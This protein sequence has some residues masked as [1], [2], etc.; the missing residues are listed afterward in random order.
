MIDI[1]REEKTLRPTIL[2]NAAVPVFSSIRLQL[3]EIE[4]L[5][6]KYLYQGVNGEPREDTVQDAHQWLKAGY[7]VCSMNLERDIMSVSTLPSTV[8]GLLLTPPHSELRCNLYRSPVGAGIDLHFDGT[9][10]II[11]QYSGQKNWWV[12]RQR[13][14]PN[15]H[16]SGNHFPVSD[17][18]ESCYDG[19]RISRPREEELDLFV[20]NPGDILVLPRGYWHKTIATSTSTSLTIAAMRSFKSS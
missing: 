16:V 13:A 1:E 9:D 10:S 6:N 17:S 2:R 3:S 4:T 15:E 5:R 19:R 18:S 14:L 7:T 11:L 12:S 20:L 8:Y